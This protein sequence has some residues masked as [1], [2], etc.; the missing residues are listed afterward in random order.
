L[1]GGATCAPVLRMA[2]NMVLRAQRTRRRRHA[3]SRQDTNFFF[4]E[5]QPAAPAAHDGRP[6]DGAWR[7]TTAGQ[8]LDEGG[9][10]G[11]GCWRAAW[12]AGFGAGRKSPTV[13]AAN[14]RPSPPDGR[15]RSPPISGS[16][17]RKRRGPKPHRPPPSRDGNHTP[18]SAVTPPPSPS[19][20]R[21]LP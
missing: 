11:G 10:A 4:D 21:R 15:T 17:S 1:A 7:H 12:C 18:A 9:L 3:T 19:R 8:Q 20:C 5:P 13:S 2:H 14:R 16:L 6:L